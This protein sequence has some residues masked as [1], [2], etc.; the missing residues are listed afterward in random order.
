MKNALHLCSMVL[1]CLPVLYLTIFSTALTAANTAEHFSTCNRSPV[2]TC[3]QNYF[4]CLG[5]DTSPAS[6]GAATAVAGENDCEV[7]VVSFEDEVEGTDACA[8]G[9]LIKR[10]W[11]ADYPDGADPWLFAECTQVILLEDD[12]LPVITDCPTNITVDPDNG[13]TATVAW[14]PPFASDDCGIVFFES[15]VQN[16][17]VFPAGVTTVIYTARDACGNESTCSFTVTVNATGCQD[18][19]T[20]SCPPNFSGC[21]GQDLDPIFT[22]T[23]AASFADPSCGTPNVTFRDVVVSTGGACAQNRTI[24]RTWT[25]TNGANSNLSASCVQLIETQDNE[26]PV[27]ITC[28]EDL[29]NSTISPSGIVIIYDD[30]VVTDD[31]GI[32]SVV[33][34]IPSGSVFTPGVT[35]VT[36]TITDLC[37]NVAT[38][39]FEITVILVQ[40]QDPPVIDCPDTFEGCVS[41]SSDPS[42]TGMATATFSS[43]TCMNTPDV[44][45]SDVVIST[46]S[47]AGTRLI[48]RTWTATNPDDFTM[49]TSCVQRINLRDQTVPTI[50]TCPQDI[51][52]GSSSTSGRVVNF[53]DVVA[54]DNCGIASVTYSTQSGSVFPLGTTTVQVTVTDA[55][56]NSN[57][58]FFSVQVLLDQACQE[59]PNISCP[60]NMDLCVGESTDP[61]F[62]GQATASFSSNNCSSDAI[63]TFSDQVVATGTCANA[64]TIQRTWTA[65]N[66]DNSV[67]TSSCTQ[68]ITVDDTQAP[69]ISQC[70][71]DITQST[72]SPSGI[73]VNYSQPTVSDDC[74]IAATSFSKPSGSVFTPGV[75][76]VTFTVTDLCGRVSTCS[77]T[78]TVNMAMAGCQSSPNMGCPADFTGCPSSSTSPSVTGMATASYGASSGCTGSPTITFRDEIVSQGPCNGATRINRIWTATNPDNGQSVSCTQRITLV[79]TQAPTITNCPSNATISSAQSTYSWAMPTVTDNCGGTTISASVANGSTF[80]IGTTTVTLTATDGCG[81]QSSCSFTV[82]VVQAGCQA[83]PT[84]SCP[85][86]FTGCPGTSTSPSVTG[87]ATGSFGSATGCSAS[88]T[89]TFTD[90]IVSQGPCNGATTINRIWTATNPDNGQAVS[91]TQVISLVDTQA[92]TLTNCPAS[93]TI[94]SDHGAYSWTSPTVTDNCAG[95]IT[96]HSDVANG[97][98]FP[99]GTTQVTI[100]AKDACGNNSSCSFS[101]T[102]VESGCQAIPTIN[103]PA[104][105]TA[106]PGSSTSPSV[107][108]MATGSFGSASG[109]PSTPTI[110]FTDQIVAQGPCRGAMTI[111]RIWTATNP[112]NG[113]SVSCTQRITLADT[114]APTITNCP[115]DVTISASQANYS[116]MTPTVTDNCGA[117]LTS[118]VT[119]GSQFPIGSTTVTLTARDNCGN[120]TTCSFVVTV[121][122]ETTT[123]GGTGNG[124]TGSGS[125]SVTCPSDMVMACDDNTSASIPQPQVSSSCDLCA[126]GDISGFLFIGNFR[127]TNYYLSRTKA[128]WPRARTEASNIGGFLAKIESAEENHFLAS[129]LPVNSAYI[130]LSD[131]IEEGTFK[132][133]DG[134]VPTYTNWYPRQP[135]DYQGKQDY[136]ELL[137]NGLW[138]DQFNYEKLLFIVELPC[139]SVRQT[140]GPT[141]LKNLSSSTRVEF[142][143]TDACGNVETCSFA[144]QVEQRLSIECPDDIAVETSA[145]GAYVA[146]S[147][148]EV[149]TCCTAGNAQPRSID[150]FIYMGYH[151]GSYYYCSRSNA[152]WSQANATSR[153]LGGYLATIESPAENN[154]LAR[155]LITQSAFIGVSD[156]ITEGRF[157]NVNNREINYASWGAHQPS[158]TG[159]SQHFVEMN[160]YGEWNDVAADAQREYIMEVPADVRF[161]LVEGVPSGGAFPV[162][163]TRVTVR[164]TDACGVSETCSFN[165]TVS[166]PNTGG[167]TTCRSFAQRSDLGFIKES[168]VGNLL[169]KTG[170]NGGF[171]DLTEYCLDVYEGGE[172]DVRFTP[173]FGSQAYLAYYHF[174][175]D[176]NGDGDFEDERELIGT[177]RSSNVIAGTFPIPIGTKIGKIRMRVIMSLNGF[178]KSPCDVIAF[179]EVEDYCLNVRAYRGEALA[180]GRSD[181][182]IVELQGQGGIDNGIDF[183]QRDLQELKLT[184]SPNPVSHMMSISYDATNVAEAQIIDL[185]GQVVRTIDDLSMRLDVSDYSAGMY[186]LRVIHHDGTSKVEKFII[187]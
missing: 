130:G 43:M 4:G 97:S 112:D 95:T 1:S 176:F 158:N 128:T 132:W 159:G 179:G 168:K 41:S 148:P 131:E 136:V 124:G 27:I 39:T 23:P 7:P 28:Q 69:V 139:V 49:T 29:E 161:T 82:T 99:V 51:V 156:H 173:G 71:A 32:A 60:A 178:P 183:N 21:V 15:N 42:I 184:I 70:P 64:R 75:T 56:D 169:F 76:T 121:E 92:P 54:T 185:K 134:E 98:V 138:N 83:T 144:V 186:L 117:S 58:C 37:G 2:I 140:A 30:P 123:G 25:A 106:C 47:C 109:C 35:P 89:I 19:P 143:V 150:G 137:K 93:V 61:A 107:T 55:C 84:I 20:I 157:F 182:G 162:G 9:I 11:R 73:V 165:V 115:I 113:Q 146:Y 110:T 108:G 44:T 36:F 65:T 77:F 111:D 102:V 67:L 174:Y 175:I 180:K 167:A 122:E 149:T 164:A 187:E 100:N 34:S 101:V 181:I 153:S 88:P 126:G 66:P 24:E 80:P 127:G 52:I 142:E 3:P 91:C 152:T 45:F 129:R 163:T 166:N 16:G 31:C 81:N 118:N 6:V 78:V 14:A 48:E 46:G 50:V 145:N 87:M 8:G 74:G 63:I 147:L 114:Q 125:L 33:P 38:C 22:G 40:C 119:N 59:S 171:A 13:T 79:D 72:T 105:Y 10:T 57:T 104:N 96:L 94:S 62:T 85:A 133:T 53:P 135:N 116:W 103:C 120:T 155:Q 17:S 172:F 90:Q 68:V 154:F 141:T 26:P 177:S 86:S 18:V 170:N 160:P 5:D 151:G 12:E